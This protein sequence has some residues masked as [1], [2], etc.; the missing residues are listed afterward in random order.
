MNISLRFTDFF[1][2]RRIFKLFFVIFMLKLDEPFRDE[3]ILDN[4]SFFKRSDLGFESERFLF[5][6]LPTGSEAVDPHIFA[7]PDPRSQNVADPTDPDP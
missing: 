3:D 2:R 5:D 6:I 1:I 4:L 7:D